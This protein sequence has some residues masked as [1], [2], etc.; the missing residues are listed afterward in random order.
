MVL[1][2]LLLDLIA[3]GSYFL[4]TANPNPPIFLLLAIVESV[5]VVLLICLLLLI[6]VSDT[7]G[8]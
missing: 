7:P 8:F 1:I 2:S 4:V 6:A 5:I 3:F